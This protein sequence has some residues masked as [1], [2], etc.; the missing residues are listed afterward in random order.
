MFASTGPHFDTGSD[1]LQTIQADQYPGFCVGGGVST[2]GSHD[3]SRNH[4]T[5]TE[6]QRC[7]GENAGPQQ[8]HYPGIT[9]L[10]CVKP[11]KT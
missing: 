2:P 11:V 8:I 7:N 9:G 1:A 6:F 3:L 5:G 10:L 4:L